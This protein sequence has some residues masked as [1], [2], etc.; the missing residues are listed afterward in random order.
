ME[1]YRVHTPSHAGVRLRTEPLVTATNALTIL[2]EGHSVTKVSE[3]NKGWWQIRAQINGKE[4]EGFTSSRYLVPLPNEGV[5][6][7]LPLLP[8]AH[9]TEGRSV[10]TRNTEKYRAY[11]LGEIPR[12]GRLAGSSAE[13]VQQLS[14]IIDYLDVERSVRY[15]PKAPETYC[16]I[17]SCD[18][19]YLA[20]AYLPRVWWTPDALR[21]LARQE[22]VKPV[23]A[24]TVTELNANA[25]LGWF[26]QYGLEFGWKE[27]ASLDE[28]QQAAN[29]G[30]VCIIVARCTDA[31]R[32]GHIVAVA[33]ENQT[34]QAKRTNGK[35]TV[36]LQSEA[37]LKNRKYGTSSTW[38]KDVKFKDFGYFIFS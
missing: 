5:A 25:L 34:H 23:Y 7:P 32:S 8:P 17:Y 26:R 22:E 24:E 18:Y 1:T 38:W 35:V 6:P 9:L 4:I 28:I 29:Q 16:N 11:P 14:K 15:Q 21:K 13:R 2:P 37:G 19:C 12:P 3:A 20:G 36:P 33:P 31:R 10:V 27:T 30:H